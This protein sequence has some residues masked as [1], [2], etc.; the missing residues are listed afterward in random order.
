METGGVGIG[1][2]REEFGVT[3]AIGVDTEAI[4]VETGGTGGHWGGDSG[5]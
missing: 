5:H 4:G 2:V 3:R 1:G